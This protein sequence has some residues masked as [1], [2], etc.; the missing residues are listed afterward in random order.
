[1]LK[2]NKKSIAVAFFAIL[3]FAVM[4]ACDYLNGS[5]P[6]SQGCTDDTCQGICY[7]NQTWATTF[8]CSSSLA[9]CCECRSDWY[10]CYGYLCWETDG[11]LST[12]F[13]YGGGSFCTR[14]G[15]CS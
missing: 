11:R 5:F 6:G 13:E 8:E 3:P 10:D 2:L 15:R 14:F 12:G 1:M 4:A 9:G 7:Y